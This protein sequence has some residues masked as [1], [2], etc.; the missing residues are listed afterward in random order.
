M[1]G[2]TTAELVTPT[3][4]LARVRAV[5]AGVRAGEVALLVLAAQW[6]DAHPD[7]DPVSRLDPD[8]VD[9]P[10]D[11]VDPLVPAMA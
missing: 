10:R 5:Q 6:A 4:M 9:D 2:M 3:V 11:V 1:V 8:D 7:L